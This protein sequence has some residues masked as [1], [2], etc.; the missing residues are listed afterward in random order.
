MLK[1]ID[2]I[3]NDMWWQEEDIIRNHQQ[4]VS[5]KHYMCTSN[6]YH[7]Y[8]LRA[9][10]NNNELSKTLDKYVPERD[11]NIILRPVSHGIMNPSRC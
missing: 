11:R 4:I 7:T 9:D 3:N 5:N 6:S 2:I 10:A 1:K 8:Y